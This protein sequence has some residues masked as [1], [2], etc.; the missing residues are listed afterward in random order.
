M[1]RRHG[2]RHR[3]YLQI[4]FALVVTLAVFAAIANGLWRL[5]EESSRP[6]QPALFLT[7]LPAA[8]IP[9]PGAPSRVQQRALDRLAARLG[10]RVSLFAADARLVAA[11]GPALPAP[12]RPAGRDVQRYRDGR[13]QVWARRLPD[14]RWL[15]VQPRPA[16][17]PH[18][19]PIGVLVLIAL[20]AYPAVRRITRRLERL[21]ASVEALGAGD[22]RARVPVE[23]RDE[24]AQLAE[25]F[26]RAATRIEALVTAH[27]T[28][29]A[30]ASHE[31][32]SP[33]ARLRVAIELL[34]THIPAAQRVEVERNIAELDALIEEILLASR[35]DTTPDHGSVEPVDLLGLVAEEAARRDLSVT[36]TPVQVSGETRLLRRLIRNLLDNAQRYGRSPI[37][38]AVTRVNEDAALTV[39]DRGPGIPVSER[40]RI[41]EP[42]YRLPGQREGDGGS[43]LGLAIVRQIARRHGGEALCEARPDGGTCFRV[44]LPAA[45]PAGGGPLRASSGT[46]PLAKLSTPVH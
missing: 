33:L 27:K 38:I 32:R 36:G 7:D 11:S 37:D 41:F 26:N 13:R 35:L 16:G 42:F 40:E 25:S 46:A 2:P 31:L 1:S 43:G 29:L 23:G 45:T 39:C 6:R 44:T 3:L 5:T 30:N 17:R 28:L 21:Q 19:G 24:V 34:H 22:L 18:W 10:G 12:P 20:A 8:A 9:A 15:A 14:G 4:Y